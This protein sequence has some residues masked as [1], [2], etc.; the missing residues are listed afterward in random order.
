MLGFPGRRKNF[1]F[2][3]KCGKMEALFEADNISNKSLY[4]ET[5]A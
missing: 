2:S 5:F 1:R 4:R 3:Q